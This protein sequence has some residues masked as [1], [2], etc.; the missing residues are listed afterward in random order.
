MRVSTHSLNPGAH[1]SH[2]GWG[3]GSGLHFACVGFPAAIHLSKATAADNA[4]HAEVIHGQLE[5]GCN[6]EGEEERLQAITRLHWSK[7]VI[8]HMT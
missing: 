4:V 2:T 1:P 5:G 6:R 7:F 8:C 3:R